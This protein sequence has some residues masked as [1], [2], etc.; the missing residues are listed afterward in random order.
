MKI[1]SVNAGSSSLKFSAFEM[2]EEKKLISGYFQRI[3]IGK[4]FYTL[5]VNGEKKQVEVEMQNH[6]EAFQILIQELIENHIVN[7]LSEIKGIGHRVVH[8]GEY[9]QESAI[10]DESV[11]EKIAELSALAPLH[12]PPAVVGIR[13]AMEVVPNATQVVVF[14]TSFHQTMERETYLYALP[15]NWYRDYKVRKYGAHGTSHK[16]ITERMEGVL[17]KKDTKLIICH[18]GSGA[19]ISAIK[20][21]KCINTSMGFTPNA[22]LIMGTR[23]GDIDASII[24]YMMKQANI[25]SEEMDNIINKESGVLAISEQYSDMRDIYDNVKLGEEKSILALNMYVRRIVDYIAKYYFELKGCDAIIFT[26]GVG[27]NGA[28]ER[29]KIVEQLEFLGIHLNAPFN[30]QIASYHDIHEGK[31]TTDDSSIPVYVIPT[32]EEIMIARDTFHLQNK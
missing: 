6:S 26:A 16:Y 13:A 32:D 17:G 30:E 20:N 10:V 14:D 15:M 24:P 23:C 21:G 1:L 22:G 7:D 3:G 28:Y 9:F 8:G 27:E 18:I 12:N 25:T 29:S 11:I 5:K 31:I 19:S 4:S 2:P